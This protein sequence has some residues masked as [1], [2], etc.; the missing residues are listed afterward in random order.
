MCR[1]VSDLFFLR[2]HTRAQIFLT[3]FEDPSTFMKFIPFR[4]ST[5]A[6]QESTKIGTSR[7]GSFRIGSFRLGSFRETSPRQDSKSDRRSG[8]TKMGAAALDSEDES[9]DSCTSRFISN[10]EPGEEV[11]TTKRADPVVSHVLLRY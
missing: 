4:N 11:T 8:S 10:V 7:L 2:T 5:I 3:C 9:F 6:P 1:N